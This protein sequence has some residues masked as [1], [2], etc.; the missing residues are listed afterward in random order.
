[1]TSPLAPCG[2]ERLQ[3]EADGLRSVLKAAEVLG[4]VRDMN[5][6]T[7]V[8]GSLYMLINFDSDNVEVQRA[9]REAASALRFIL[10]LPRPLEYMTVLGMTSG[11]AAAMV[12]GAQLLRSSGMQHTWGWGA[13]TRSDLGS[14]ARRWRCRWHRPLGK[15]LKIGLL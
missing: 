9:V 2:S 10:E 11:S 12:S 15:I 13:H 3:S 5:V 14:S 7:V 1:M 6:F 4:D 8:F